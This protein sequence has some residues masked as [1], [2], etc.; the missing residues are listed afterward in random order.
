MILQAGVPSSLSLAELWTLGTVSPVI[1][2]VLCLCTGDLLL[3]LPRSLKELFQLPWESHGVR[4][5]LLKS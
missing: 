5:P 4:R 1:L 2:K 3:P